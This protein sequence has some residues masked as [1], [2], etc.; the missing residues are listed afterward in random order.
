MDSQGKT[1]LPLRRPAVKNEINSGLMDVD[2]K[3]ILKKALKV[4]K[5]LGICIVVLWVV[6]LVVLQLMLTENF[7]RAAAEKYLPE[8]IE[9]ADVKFAHI[10]ASAIK[11]FPNLR[12]EIDSLTITYPHEK[13][14]AYDSLPGVQNRLAKAGRG[15]VSDTLASFS[16]ISVSV[17]YIALIKGTVSISEAVMKDSRVFVRQFDSTQSNLNVFKFMNSAADSTAVEEEEGE[18]ADVVLHHIGLKGRTMAVYTNTADTLF[19][20]LGSRNIDI[21]G[22]IA[23]RK[24]L[25]AKLFVDIDSTFVSGRTAT[26]TVSAGFKHLDIDRRHGYHHI[27]AEGG[28]FLAMGGSGRMM[29]PI[30]LET[31]LKFPDYTPDKISIKHLRLKLASLSLKG[32]SDLEFMGDSLGIRAKASVDTCNVQKLLKDFAP[33]IGPEAGKL[34]SDANVSFDVEC[35]GVMAFDPMRLPQLTGHLLI[36]ESKISHADVPEAGRIAADIEFTADKKGVVTANAGKLSVAFAG[37]KLDGKGTAKNLTGVDPLLTMDASA[38]AVLEK[39]NTFLPDGMTA[40]GRVDAKLKGSAR[41]SE[42]GPGNF[43]GANLE[44]YLVSDGITIKDSTMF[45]YLGK[46]DV[47]LTKKP[48]KRGDINQ[49]MLMVEGQI[50]SVYAAMGPVMKIRGKSMDVAISDVDAS[51]HAN[52][53]SMI[54]EDSLFVALRNSRNYISIKKEVT[55][56][57]KTGYVAISSDNE[58]L[59]LRQGRQAVGLRKAQL[60]TNGKRRFASQMRSRREKMLDSLQKIWPGVPRDSL[61]RKMLRQKYGDRR[62]RGYSREAAMYEQEDKAFRSQD[63]SLRLDESLAK[64]FREWEINGFVNVERGFASTPSFPLRTRLSGLQG[65]FNNNEV[66]IDSVGVKSGKSDVAA[67]VSITGLRRALLGRGKVTVDLNVHS[68]YLHANELIAA[69]DAGQR[70]DES[71][72]NVVSENELSESNVVTMEL[73]DSA[74]HVPFIVVPANLNVSIAVTGDTIKYSSLIIDSFKSKILMKDRCLQ[75]SGTTATSNMG[76]ISLE[77][78]YASRSRQDLSVGFDLNLNEITAD[79]VITMIPQ[80]DTLLP[81]LKTFRGELDCEFAATS[82]LDTNMNFIPETIN[83]LMEINGHNLTIEQNKAIRKIT[84]LLLFKNKKTGAIDEMSVRGIIGDNQMEI[85][86]F[87]LTVDRYKLALG[88]LQNFDGSFQYHLSVLK[89]PIPWKFGINIKGNF[90][91]WKLR[92]G[93]AKYKK[94]DT[95]VYTR[96]LDTARRNLLTSI[97]SIFDKGVALAL[98]ENRSE[99]SGIKSA[100]YSAVAVSG[101]EVETADTL[102]SWQLKQMDSMVVA[103]DSLELR[104]SLVRD[105]LVRDSLLIKPAQPEEAKTAEPLAAALENKKFVLSLQPFRTQIVAASQGYLRRRARVTAFRKVSRVC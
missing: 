42:F 15:E 92:F 80:V 104:D 10:R 61:F 89:S 70:Y 96:Q 57:G 56:G 59:F 82:A 75:L 52:R 11:S 27:T 101:A 2:Y 98:E 90:D 25:H 65:S 69:I 53:L 83:G 77:G 29:L 43:A 60:S 81:L 30:K 48:R 45:A 100:D 9:G 94:I 91:K 55:E 93:G 85:F 21:D 72:D 67:N 74:A 22:T 76:K 62:S 13:W 18:P 78:F 105:S 63:I 19:G 47:Q 1:L 99:M 12:V 34:K 46:T 36:P 4:L 79:K 84:K 49:M 58:G 14:A 26:D 102:S 50:D 28:T 8:V 44:G 88:G 86:P 73:D 17:S 33:L 66:K 35:N 37:I 3:K 68:K 64:Y 103:N 7:L 31:L 38:S 95:P 97:R 6:L 40:Q 16:N 71:Q 32:E 54:G 5:V 20:A 87:N 51:V 41:L 39:L 23:L 24:P